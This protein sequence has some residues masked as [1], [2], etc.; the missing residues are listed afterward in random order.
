MKNVCTLILEYFIY[1]VK[2]HFSIANY[3]TTP[4]SKNPSL[5]YMRLGGKGSKVYH[6]SQGK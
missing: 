2:Y 6:T 3:E 1:Q 4:A 5:I